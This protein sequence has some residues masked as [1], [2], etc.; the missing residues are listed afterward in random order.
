LSKKITAHLAILGANTIYG[1]NYVIAK[2]IM[3]DFMQPRAIIFLRGTGAVILFWI[4][5]Q[6]FPKEK[7]AFKDLLRLALAAFFGVFMNQVL[8]FEG[9]NLTTPINAS[10][11]V[12]VIPVLVLVFAQ[13][14]L[15]ERITSF[16]VI[17]IISGATGA[18]MVILTGGEISLASDTF[19]GN[20]L[21]FINAAAFAAYLVLV[22]PLMLKYHPITVIK[23]I[24][25]F[26]AIYIIPVSAGVFVKTDFSAI[27]LEI[28]GSILYVIVG[29]TVLAYL[30]NNYSLRILSPTITGTYIYL[31][32]VLASI[33]ALAV[34]MDTLNTTDVFA[35]LLIF[36]GV[37]F[38]SRKP[39]K[40]QKKY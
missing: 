27:P 9:L 21:V 37:Y 25:L 29:T 36:A 18:I 28:W 6:F 10:I 2:G 17:G 40:K 12:T 11:I 15:K 30:L 26:G 20:V 1:L 8:F 4:V 24:F 32:P 3:P 13:F 35:A 34:G 22:K 23:Y 31:Q 38:V 19:L 5:A 39:W 33:A 16:K 7:P 14:L